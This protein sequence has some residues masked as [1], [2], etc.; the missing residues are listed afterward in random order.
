MRMAARIGIN[1]FGRIGKLVLRLSLETTD[2]QIVQ[3]N[4]PMPIDLMAHLLT[5]DS[6]HGKLQAEVGHDAQ[7]LIID[8]RSIH[9]TGAV[10]P[11]DIL[12]RQNGVEFVIDASGKFMDRP[13]LLGH[14]ENGA[15]KIILSCPARDESLDRTVV[16]GV[17]HQDLM[18]GDAFVSNASCTT[19]CVAIVLRV[20][21]NEFGVKRAFMN[22]VHPVTN[23][24]N[25]QDGPHSDFRRARSAIRNIIPTTTSAVPAIQ[26]IFPEMRGHFDGLATRVPVADCSFV[27]L[28]AQL[29][30]AVCREEIN[31]AFRAQAARE[32]A[33]YL[34]YCADPIVSSDVSRN[35]HSAVFDAL[36]TKVLDGDLIQVLAW[37]DNETGY[38]ARICDLLRLMVKGT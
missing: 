34:E 5:Y 26:V 35:R 38:A 17:N 10:R 31:A 11:A 27:E 28:T 18:P 20:L 2:L 12:W 23:N 25:L 16:M 32:L 8:G 3:V 9:V 29:R 1:G 19:N 6:L 37:Y 7:H 21:M 14:L 22:T 15:R 13:S 30:R 24:Q 4:D 33:G 36:A